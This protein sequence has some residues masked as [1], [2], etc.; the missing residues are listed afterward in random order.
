MERHL[1]QLLATTHPRLVVMS[2]MPFWDAARIDDP[3][4]Y[5]EGYIVA[6]SWADRLHLFGDNLWSESVEAPVIGP[7]SAW[8]KAHSAVARV[9]LPALYRLHRAPGAHARAVAAGQ[10]RSI[11][12]SAE[13]IALASRR[14]ADAGAAFLAVLLDS[15][16][17]AFLATSQ[18]LESALA[19][20]HV[21]CVSIDRLLG[22]L[23]WTP[24]RHVKDG[25]WNR[26]GHR[27][28]AG[29]LA[30][31]VAARVESVGHVE[32]PASA[33]AAD[34]DAQAVPRAAGAGG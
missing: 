31:L 12:G 14:A 15:R 19:A 33:P 4:V 18:H 5:K 3:F 34:A 8:A 10:A 9:A 30:P 13:Q 32:S 25:H 16:S 1:E 20:R 6:A 17:P 11:E 21:D 29:A 22:H 26:E 7:A 24:L 2:L 27:A 28:V 23:D